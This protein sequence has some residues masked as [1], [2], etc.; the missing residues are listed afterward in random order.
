MF[1]NPKV[2]GTLEIGS[3]MPNLRYPG[4][5]TRADAD[6]S[7]LMSK[8]GCQEMGCSTIEEFTGAVAKVASICGTA[9][10]SF[11]PKLSRDDPDARLLACL[12]QRRRVEREALQRQVL[13]LQICRVR[14]RIKRRTYALRCAQAVQSMSCL[15][16]FRRPRRRKVTFLCHDVEEGAKN[17]ISDAAEMSSMVTNF[18][19]SL[20]EQQGFDIPEWINHTFMLSD[21]AHLPQVDGH[22][23]RTAANALLKNKTCASDS[24]V[25]E[26]VQE[27]D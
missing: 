1:S 19:E 10:K 5:F 26:M 11:A 7:Q 22:L 23:V 20:F 3:H 27:L 4:Y 15:R 8:A 6:C 12:T 13:S 2:S 16:S 18:F 25:A 24:V 21:L 17:P 9:C 14:R